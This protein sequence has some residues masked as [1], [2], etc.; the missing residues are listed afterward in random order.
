[1]ADY[2]LPRTTI[3]YRQ[4]P[5]VKSHL[6]SFGQD[7]LEQSGKNLAGGGRSRKKTQ[8]S[9]FETQD[10]IAYHEEFGKEKL[11][12]ITLAN[13]GR[14]G[15]DDTGV[16]CEANTFMMTGKDIKYLC[17]MLNTNLIR[18]YLQQIAPTSGMGT[19]LW[20]K[21][22]VETIPIPRISAAKNRPISRLVEDILSAKAADPTVD[23]SDQ[24]ADLDQRAY[25]L[26][27]LTDEEINAI[28]V[29]DKP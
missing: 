22:Y 28:I 3:G 4:L 21:V 1:M 6:L 12:W 18:W 29:V 14:F 15:Y 17:A 16:Y 11:V 7:R 25:L 8:H 26:Y 13:N 2:D 20:K 5:A 27:G 23:T 24:E 9:W 10:S 19:L